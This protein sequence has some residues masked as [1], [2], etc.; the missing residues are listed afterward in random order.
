MNQIND[1]DVIGDEPNTAEEQIRHMVVDD[2]IST[3]NDENEKEGEDDEYEQQNRPQN[4]DNDNDNNNNNNNNNNNKP[5]KGDFEP[6]DIASIRSEKQTKRVPGKLI[7]KFWKELDP[8]TLTALDKIIGI[9][10]NK[11]IERYRTKDST[12]N[13]KM[14]ETERILY[15]TWLSLAANKSFR[16]RLSVTKFPRIN[17]MH[18]GMSNKGDE[19]AAILNYDR[20]VRRK[21][22]LETYIL[23][24]LKQLNELQNYYNKLKLSYES[25][26]KYLNEFKRT[27]AIN[28]SKMSNEL[29]NHEL[30]YE[31]STDDINLSTSSIK[32]HRNSETSFNPNTDSTVKSLLQSLSENIDKIDVSDLVD[33]KDRLQSFENYLD[34]Q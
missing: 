4:P 27:V 28:Q 23:A 24:E 25:D 31:K 32:M 15:K 6:F 19:N 13:K 30:K 5:I 29:M 8:Q 21:N 20:L 10:I 12:L 34:V 3:V 2:V 1:R 22:F 7:D 14:V 26:H 17:S 16:K 9:S 11:T 33:L 18:T